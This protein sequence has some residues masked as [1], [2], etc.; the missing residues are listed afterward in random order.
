MVQR[1]SK[2]ISSIEPNLCNDEI[3]DFVAQSEKF[4]PHFHIPLQSGSN[5]ILASMKR[6]YK[7]ELYADRV[8]KIRAVMPSACIGVDVIVGYP[9]ESE[10]HF[11]ETYHFLEGLDISYL[12]VFTYSERANTPAATMD[13]SIDMHLR[14]KRN[15][16]LRNLSSQKKAAFYKRHG[17]SIGPVLFEKENKDGY[18]YGFTENY[19]KVRVDAAYS[20][21]LVN[22]MEG[23][24]KNFE[25]VLD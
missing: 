20:N 7:R 21:T 5:A 12:H 2:G 3:I 16:M 25:L 13:G 9:G 24:E 6:R 17:K 19:L 22:V 8:T 4:V 11:L 23:R 15:E 18:M 14:R 10:D 1:S